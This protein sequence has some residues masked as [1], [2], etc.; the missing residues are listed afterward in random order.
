VWAGEEQCDDGDADNTDACLSTCN[1]ATC[2]DGF[3]RNDLVAPEVCDDGNMEQQ[4]TAASWVASTR[5]AVTASSVTGVEQCDDG[6]MDNADACTDICRNAECGDGFVQG[7][8]ICDDGNLSNADACLVTCVA[9]SC[10]DGFAQTGV[11]ACDDGNGSNLDSCLVG[12]VAATCGDG[13]VYT[14][15]ES[16]DDGNMAPT[17]TVATRTAR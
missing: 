8:E 10:G 6:N 7:D 15:V 4:R 11:E 17:A 14:G 3:V 2:G 5:R 13:N 12:C 16:C 9:A 1:L